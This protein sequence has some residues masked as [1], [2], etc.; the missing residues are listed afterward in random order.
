[1][2]ISGDEE[3]GS[4]IIDR[5][6]RKDHETSFGRARGNSDGDSYD[7][8]DSRRKLARSGAPRPPPGRYRPYP[9]DSRPNFDWEG[10]YT[11]ALFQGNS[12]SSNRPP[13]R[14]SR[15]SESYGRGRDRGG[16][17][18]E[19]WD[20]W[21]RSGGGRQE[22]FLHPPL[23]EEKVLYEYEGYDGHAGGRRRYRS[24]G[25]GAPVMHVQRGDSNM[26]P[27]SKR[28]IQLDR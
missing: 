12:G 28:P 13:Y 24:P 2:N 26:D 19:G 15:S 25:E 22:D 8:D 5:G 4:P 17:W 7:F 9:R 18:G 23:P 1:V 14:R 21:T 6:K 20:D 16:W 3:L 11:P 10:R 27:P